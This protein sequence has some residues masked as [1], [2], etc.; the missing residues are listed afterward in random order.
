M[1][2]F[3]GDSKQ[4]VIKT[5]WLIILEVIV[6]VHLDFHYTIVV[7]D[8]TT[9]QTDIMGMVIFNIRYYIFVLM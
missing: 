1:P 7:K 2:P 3:R 9:R 4:F 8:K 6:K 5:F